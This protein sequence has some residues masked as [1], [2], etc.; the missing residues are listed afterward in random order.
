M[1]TLNSSIAARRE[2]LQRQKSSNYHNEIS[3][4]AGRLDEHL[5]RSAPDQVIAT[6]RIDS[7]RDKLQNMQPIIGRQGAYSIF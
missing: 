2:F 7:L 1:Q 4:L 3:R 5:I 6:R